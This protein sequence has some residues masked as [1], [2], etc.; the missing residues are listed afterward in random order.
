MAL[1][2][3]NTINMPKRIKMMNVGINHHFLRSFMYNQKSL[4][5]SILRVLLQI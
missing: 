1:P 4:K 2:E 3:L 5:K